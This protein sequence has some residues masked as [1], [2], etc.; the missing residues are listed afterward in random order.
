MLTE[1]DESVPA[2]VLAEFAAAIAEGREPAV[3][4]ED[5]AAVL[6]VAEAA[7]FS[8]G[9]EAAC[10]LVGGCHELA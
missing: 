5:G 6:R 9:A 3:T 2:R 10:K 8:W 1:A 7:A 4:G